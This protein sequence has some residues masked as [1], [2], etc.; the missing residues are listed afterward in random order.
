MLRGGYFINTEFV[1]FIGI[2]IRKYITNYTYHFLV[3]E[4]GLKR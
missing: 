2:Q 1:G 3:Y 4:G